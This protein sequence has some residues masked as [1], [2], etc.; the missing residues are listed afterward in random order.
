[1]PGV[2]PPG[3]AMPVIATARLTSACSSAPNA[4][5]VAVSLLTAPKVVS[6]AVSTPSIA[7]LASL[8]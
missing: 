4:I 7:C 1:M 6:V 3:P 8:E 2:A 5:A